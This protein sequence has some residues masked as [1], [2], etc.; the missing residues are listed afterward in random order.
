VHRV[1]SKHPVLLASGKTLF[2]IEPIIFIIKATSNPK[3][4]VTFEK[5]S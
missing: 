5:T 1:G 3:M 2:A 4:I